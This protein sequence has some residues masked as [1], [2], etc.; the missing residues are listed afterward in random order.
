MYFVNVTNIVER[1]T[2]CTHLSFYTHIM[3]CGQLVPTTV[4]II[5]VI[6]ANV[7][8]VGTDRTVRYVP[9]PTLRYFA[10]GFLPIIS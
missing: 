3:S 10:V 1:Y 5:K 4:I 6:D 7:P 9:Y 8:H 2:S